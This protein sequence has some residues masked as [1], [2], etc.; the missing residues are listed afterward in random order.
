MTR[1]YLALFVTGLFLHIWLTA[2]VDTF[3]RV[4]P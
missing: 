3:A 4:T 1:A 2:M